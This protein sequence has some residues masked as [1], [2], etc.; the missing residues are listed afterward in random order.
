MVSKRELRWR[1]MADSGFEL[2]HIALQVYEPS[3]SQVYNPLSALDRLD[4]MARQGDTGAMC[5]YGAIA[6]GLPQS[7]VDWTPQWKLARKWMEK[8]ASLRHPECLIGLG[9][10]LALGSDGYIK[11][12]RRGTQM[13]FEAIAKGYIH[14]AGV[15][16]VISASR[17]LGT[18]EDRQ[19]EYCWGYQVAKYADYTPGNALE[20]YSS[21]LPQEKRAVVSSELNLLR[22]WHPTANECINLF[23]K[24]HGSGN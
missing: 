7:A 6:F 8:G 3:T 20:V 13:L 24:A 22:E 2:A 11:D 16:W 18:P 1:E 23:D 9:G 19:L 21:S 15:L 14:G 10:R 17:G 12:L 4:Q 5:L